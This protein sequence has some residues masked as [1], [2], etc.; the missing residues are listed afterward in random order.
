[1]SLKNISAQLG[2]ISSDGNKKMPP[3][4]KWN[5]DYCGE[6]DMQVKATGD[7]FYNGSIFKRLSLVKLFAFLWSVGK[8]I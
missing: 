1:M 6:I 5:P 8:G 3:V 7:W 4:E 2:G